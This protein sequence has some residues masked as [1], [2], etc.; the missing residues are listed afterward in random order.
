VF[1][2]LLSVS[3]LSLSTSIH[4]AS[5]GLIGE[6]MLTVRTYEGHSF[7]QYT[8]RISYLKRNEWRP[9]RLVY[10]T[11]NCRNNKFSIRDVDIPEVSVTTFQSSRKEQV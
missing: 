8:Q 11:C 3:L 9:S 2:M 5:M 6:Y 4:C 1:I 10:L 7:M